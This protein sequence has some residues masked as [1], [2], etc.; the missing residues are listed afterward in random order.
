[1]HCKSSVCEV[2]KCKSEAQNFG[3]CSLKELKVPYKN[4]SRFKQL[5]QKN[6]Q[7]KIQQKTVVLLAFQLIISPSLTE[8]CCWFFT[9]PYNL[10]LV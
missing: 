6:K 7:S 5:E 9:S 2:A 4:L 1:M 3:Q 8:Q 10:H